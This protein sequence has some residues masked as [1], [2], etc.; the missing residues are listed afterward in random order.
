MVGR[1]DGE[2]SLEYSNRA[3]AL[4]A[5]QRRECESCPALRRHPCSAPVKRHGVERLGGRIG[6]SFAHFRVVRFSPGTRRRES[7][8]WC[9]E[10][11]RR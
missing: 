11:Q 5:G 2:T 1:G 6:G 4:I 9:S 7:W 8:S 10:G 3:G